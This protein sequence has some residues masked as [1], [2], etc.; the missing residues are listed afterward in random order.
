MW[1]NIQRGIC[2]QI[3]QR[4]SSVEYP[5]DNLTRGNLSFITDSTESSINRTFYSIGDNNDSGILNQFS[6]I[7][8]DDY[9][10]IQYKQVSTKCPFFFGFLEAVVLPDKDSVLVFGGF[11][12]SII[13]DDNSTK[14]LN[15]S[16]ISL[17]EA[18]YSFKQNA[19][20]IVDEIHDSVN[21]S[22]IP[23]YQKGHT[24]VLA[25]NGLIYVQ[26]GHS[27]ID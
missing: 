19:W 12:E 1:L 20:S 18:R 3:I 13:S 10:N 26:G 2:M 22:L 8:F 21:P 16:I 5:V 25:S 23:S 9:G 11:E 14:F 6:Y 24:A 27:S 7:S 4:N 17:Y 15:P